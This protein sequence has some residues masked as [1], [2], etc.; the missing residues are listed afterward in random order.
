VSG[1]TPS[2]W[3]HVEFVVRHEGA[4]VVVAA[5][6]DGLVWREGVDFELGS[7]GTR[8]VSRY[9]EENPG[10]M[11][12]HYLSAAALRRASGN[13]PYPDPALGD[14]SFVASATRHNALLR[15]GFREP[16][17]E[18][19]VFVH[20]DGPVVDDWSN[21]RTAEDDQRNFVIASAIKWV[22]ANREQAREA[23]IDPELIEALHT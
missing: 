9:V 16:Y 13:P 18:G 7:L 17:S 20:P 15:L 14:A 23:G 19:T 8:L 2:E 11:R 4:E 22:L 12:E 10:A 1:P 6:V 21:W 5:Y 3:G